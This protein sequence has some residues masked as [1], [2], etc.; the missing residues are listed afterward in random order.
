MHNN[1]NALNT[2][3]VWLGSQKWPN[4]KFYVM[5][6]LPPPHTRKSEAHTVVLYLLKVQAEDAPTGIGKEGRTGFFPNLAFVIST[7]PPPILSQL[8]I[9]ILFIHLFI[10]CLLRVGPELGTENTFSS[11]QAIFC[12]AP[13]FLLSVP[14]TFRQPVL[15][16]TTFAPCFCQFSLEWK[17]LCTVPLA[18]IIFEF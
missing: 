2:T 7:F 12:T 5:N 6:I 15:Q 13:S 14:F 11:G 8:S 17:I 4:G 10:K 9:C 3:D 1:V 16:P 18:H